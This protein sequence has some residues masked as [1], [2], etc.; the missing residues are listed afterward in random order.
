MVS[1]ISSSS[2]VSLSEMR[3]KMFN[4]IDTNG[5]GSIDKTELT[6]AM[7]KNA[8][9]L[10]DEIFSK[11]DSNQD[12]MFSQLESSS[13][14]A[15][16]G[17]E[18][19]SGGAG[20]SGIQGA[21]LPPPPEKVFDT[22]DTNKDG[23]VTKDELSAVLGSQG[24][25]IDK[26]FNTVDSDGDGVISR[27]EDEAFRKKMPGQMN[28]DDASGGNLNGISS[29]SQNW[30]LEMFSALMNNF[31]AGVSAASTASTSVYA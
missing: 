31:S 21:N 22:A 12:S 5:D 23:E 4:R 7:P 13:A 27:A 2:N 29:T 26:I 19:K 3:Q 9:S 28:Q 11:V 30:Q 25:D 18:M 6:T 8:S 15:K 20:M 16:L 1:G 10:V 17:Q 24:D 14:L